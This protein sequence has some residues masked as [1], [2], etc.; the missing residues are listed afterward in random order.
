MPVVP[1]LAPKEDDLRAP[2][3]TNRTTPEVFQRTLE[4]LYI[5]RAT[6]ENL[7]R[8]LEHYRQTMDLEQPPKLRN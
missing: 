3:A 6:L 8:S 1:V 7:I 5:R 4:H 2:R